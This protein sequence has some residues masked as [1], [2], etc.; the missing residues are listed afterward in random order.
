MVLP[1]IFLKRR[2]LSIANVKAGACRIWKTLCIHLGRSIRTVFEGAD[3]RNDRD[4]RVESFF[5]HLDVELWSEVVELMMSPQISEPHADGQVQDS[6]SFYYGSQRLISG[7]CSVC[8]DYEF[9][10]VWVNEDLGPDVCRTT[11]LNILQTEPD[12][13]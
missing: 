13:I 12:T 6:R 8:I 3:S 7:F 9:Q 1:H 11:C 5:G 4:Q 10:N 2:A